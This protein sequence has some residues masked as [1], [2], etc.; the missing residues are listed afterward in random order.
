MYVGRV[1]LK[2]ISH[3]LCGYGL[4]LK[5]AGLPDPMDNFDR[6]INMRFGISDN[7]WHWTRIRLHVYGS[8]AAALEAMTSLYEEFIVDF[9]HS[10]GILC[11]CVH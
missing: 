3:F 5:S 11:T 9:G 2:D 6:W 4:G 7:E 8:D 10:A 1:S